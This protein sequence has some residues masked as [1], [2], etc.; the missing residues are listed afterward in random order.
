MKAD[1]KVVL[2]VDL[3]VAWKV[4]V[5]VDSTAAWKVSSSAAERVASMVVSRDT[6]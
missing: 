2:L 5:L 4:V 6:Y 1:M 3:K